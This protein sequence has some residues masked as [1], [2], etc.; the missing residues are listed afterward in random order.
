MFQ[1][2]RQT[3]LLLFEPEFLPL[4]HDKNVQQIWRDIL[5]LKNAEECPLNRDLTKKSLF[6]ILLARRNCRDWL[7]VYPGIVLG[8]KTSCVW[9]AI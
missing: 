7:N 8:V 6:F 3:F 4:R 1:K 5:L 2:T 9:N